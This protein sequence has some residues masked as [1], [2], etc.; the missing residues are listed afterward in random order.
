[1]DIEKFERAS[2]IKKERSMAYDTF[3]T[4]S[5]SRN[6]NNCLAAIKELP[7]K[8]FMNINTVDLSEELQKRLL[9]TVLDYIEELDKEFDKL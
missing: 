7:G 9:A 2:E 5:N 8:S 4:I 3:D 6:N 1:M